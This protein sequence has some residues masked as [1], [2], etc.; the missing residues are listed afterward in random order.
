MCEFEIVVLPG[1]QNPPTAFAG[2][3]AAICA[4]DFFFITDATATNYDAIMWY[5]TNGMG[6][7]DNETSLNPTYYPSI[8]D[9]MQGSIELYLIVNPSDPNCQIVSD[10]VILS[11]NP[12]PEASCPVYDPVEE[13][14]AYIDF[15]IIIG[16]VYTFEGNVVT[17]F[18]PVMVGN[19]VFELT[20][21]N[22]FGCVDVCEF[23]I[24]VI[25]APPVCP[26]WANLQW[27]PSGTITFGN[28]YTVYAQIW[29]DGVTQLE[30]ATPGLSVAIGYSTENTNPA[31]W[32]NWV[33]AEWNP[34]CGCGN[35]DEYMANLGAAIPQCGTYYYASRFVYNN[36]E[37]VYG[38]FN[39]GFWDGV[40][41]VSGVLTIENCGGCQNPATAFA[42]EDAAVCAGE[43]FF[44]AD[45][46]ATNYAAIQWFT[47]G[48]DGVFDDET[49]LNPT[50]YPG[51]VDMLMGSV[52]LCMMVS[53]SDP[54]CAPVLDCVTLTINPLPVA[55][56][57]D[58]VVCENGD[59]IQFPTGWDEW[60]YNW[61][62]ITSFDPSEYGPG[63]YTIVHILGNEFG[64]FD[65]CSF[66]ITVNP[67][68]TYTYE[69][70]DTE[71]CF[72]EEITW[73][74][75]FTG[76]APWTV[77]YY[78][79]GVLESYTTSDNPSITTEVLNEGGIYE[80]VS[81]TDGNGCTVLLNQPITIIVNPLPT[82]SYEVS[83]NDICYGE[84]VTF[85]NYFTGTAPW[86]VEFMYNGVL[87]SQHQ[88][89]QSIIPKLS[90]KQFFMNQFQ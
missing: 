31:T 26:G 32:S 89:I 42:G 18:D 51:F 40:N 15:P 63:E 36:C 60:Y 48:G 8:Y 69:V 10:E 74:E 45:A 78:W 39:G 80:P 20:V 90:W 66:T 85:V 61:N 3:D 7:F 14:S 16:G 19:Y 24:V 67:L 11:F 6:Y 55:T 59:V 13:G 43:N 21:T 30:G 68:P 82:H 34:F 81:V 77:E 83:D 27:P 47:T 58:M 2:A 23:E 71:L 64:C 49:A 88:K 86:T 53:P 1:C 70:S 5:T 37:T 12:L 54:Y 9:V 35:N 75:Y 56:C 4:D 62:Y 73:T 28:D 79:N 22:E 41:N 46:T 76:T 72:G 65:E 44:I 84:E 87:S 25:P 52:D 33:P 57:Q 38:G 50:Y 17:G 29:I